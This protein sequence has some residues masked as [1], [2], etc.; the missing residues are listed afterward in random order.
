M[1]TA[2]TRLHTSSNL[3][4]TQRLEPLHTCVYDADRRRN[5]AE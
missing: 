2:H 5:R 1:E 4:Q 3:S